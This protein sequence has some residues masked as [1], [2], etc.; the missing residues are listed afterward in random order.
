MLDSVDLLFLALTA[1]V[2]AFLGS[3]AGSGGSAVLLPV[4]VVYFGIRDA[5]PI[6]TIAN[7]VANASRSVINRKQIAAPVVGWF[8]LGTV[9]MAL[10]GAYLFTVATPEVLTRLLGALLIGIGVWRQLRPIPPAI[11]SARWFLPIGAVFGFLEGV[12]GSMGPVMAPFF[13]A[14]GLVKGAY[15]GT[16]ALA[17]AIIQVSKLGVFGGAALLGAREVAFGLALAPCMIAGTLAGKRLLD[18]ISKRT[19]ATIVEVMLVVAGLN[20]LLR[21]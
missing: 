17:T 2:S 10:A 12:L 20:F 18:R 3:V 16:D 15:I 4:L 9:P 19:F 14:F 6:L 8:A 7:L 21:G 11:R 13:L 1:L 5:V